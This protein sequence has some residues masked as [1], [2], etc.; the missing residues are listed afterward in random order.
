M[1]MKSFNA[2][3]T[4]D[5]NNRTSISTYSYNASF[6]YIESIKSQQFWFRFNN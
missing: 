1:T 5:Y 3:E 6:S 4:H 2:V